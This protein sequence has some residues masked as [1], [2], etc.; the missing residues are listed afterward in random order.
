LL[1]DQ[2]CGASSAVR[3]VSGR[4]DSRTIQADQRE[5][6]TKVIN[7]VLRDIIPSMNTKVEQP[8]NQAAASATSAARASGLPYEPVT[9]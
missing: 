6:K 5:G 7:I 8:S 1:N 2:L 9:A 3:N 4:D